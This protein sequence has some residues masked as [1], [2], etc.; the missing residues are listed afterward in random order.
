[1]HWRPLAHEIAAREV[2]RVIEARGLL[3]PRA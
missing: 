2:M 1:M 3:A